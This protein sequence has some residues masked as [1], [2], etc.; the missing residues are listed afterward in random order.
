[1]KVAIT[2]SN[3]NTHN[4]LGV[5]DP[6]D[7]V[8]SFEVRGTSKLGDWVEVLPEEGDGRTFVRASDVVAVHLIPEEGDEQASAQP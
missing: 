3:G 1:V 7:W 5:A 6:A 8:R 2:L 4:L